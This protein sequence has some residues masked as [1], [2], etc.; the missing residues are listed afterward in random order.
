F[1]PTQTGNVAI[2]ESGDNKANVISSY[3]A[4]DVFR[5]ERVHGK[6]IYKINN[7]VYFE[8]AVHSTSALYVDCSLYDPGAAIMDLRIGSGT[9]GEVHLV[10]NEYNELGQLI[11][12]KLHQQAG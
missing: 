9:L 12:K 2:H 8:S 4:N 6:I 10:H 1:Y 3:T 11:D 5:I 7:N